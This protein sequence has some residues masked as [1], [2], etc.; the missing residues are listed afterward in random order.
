MKKIVYPS[1]LHNA[2]IELPASKSLSHR[3]LSAASLAEGTSILHHVVDNKDTEATISV[4]KKR[5]VVFEKTD[6]EE[7]LLV[8]GIGKENHY[9]GSLLDCNES[10]STLRFMIPLFALSRGVTKFTGHGKLMERPQ[11]VYEDLFHKQGLQFEKK[12]S[13]LFVEG[14]LKAGTYHIRGDV[15]SQFITGL[16]YALPLLEESSTLIVEPPFES[17]SYV[18]MTISSLKKAG[19]VIKQNGLEFDIPGGQIYQPFEDTIEG[20]ASQMAF[21]AEAA[22]LS[23]AEIEVSTL[24]HTRIQGDE[25]AA[26]I[27]RKLGAIVRETETGYI[28]KKGDMHGG[29][30]DL[31]D[32]PDLGPAL[33]AL[34]SGCK[35][36]T[37]FLHAGRLRIKE[38]DRIAAMETEMRKLGCHITSDPDTVTVSYTEK[39]RGNVTLDGHNDHRIVMSLAVLASAADGPVA[40]EGAEAITKSY[41][42]FFED[43]EK[44]GVKVQ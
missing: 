18:A 30:V 26:D 38:S 9:D 40:I 5:G 43:L 19:I 35:G 13:I 6:A 10:G 2:K 27:V 37:T 42:S 33:F 39:I 44:T 21:F 3:A 20:D 25:A 28:F 16:L 29:V 36:T 41:P 7:T 14:P 31:A 11:S 34:A 24:S 12:D 22:C 15:S 23:E 1:S 4:L 17:A 32:C 8:H